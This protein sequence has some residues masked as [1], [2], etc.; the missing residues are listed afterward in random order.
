MDGRERLGKRGFRIRSLFASKELKKE[1]D[2]NY[3]PRVFFPINKEM[4]YFCIG[5]IQGV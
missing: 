3:L 5:A 2:T 1:R 4:Q